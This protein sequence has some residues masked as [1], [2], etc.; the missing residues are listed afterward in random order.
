MWRMWRKLRA[1]ALWAGLASLVG[2]CGVEA[3]EEVAQHAAPVAGSD[4][5]DFTNR[6]PAVLLVQPSSGGVCSGTLI[7]PNRVITAAHCFEDEVGNPQST[8]AKVIAVDYVGSDSTPLYIETRTGFVVRNPG[9][10]FDARETDM[11]L[12]L[13]QDSNG[14]AQ[15]MTTITPVDMA[16][17]EDP[18]A[19]SFT[20]TVVGFGQRGAQAPSC[21][22]T[23]T[24]DR[25]YNTSDDWELSHDGYGDTYSNSWN[26]TNV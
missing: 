19:D 11:V 9:R 6:Y 16:T 3:A 25:S 4:N 24:G 12:L 22:L 14:N 13:L 23:T 17:A 10:V 15:P 8:T 5:I 21:G 7:T 20:G 1:G 26:L 2:G 18:C